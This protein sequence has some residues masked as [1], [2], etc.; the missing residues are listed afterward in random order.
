MWAEMLSWQITAEPIVYP[1]PIQIFNSTSLPCDTYSVP[2]FTGTGGNA[3]EPREPVL[4][5]STE[6]AKTVPTSHTN[7]NCIRKCRGGKVLGTHFMIKKQPWV[8]VHPYLDP[9]RRW[10][11]SK[12]QL[13]CLFPLSLGI[14]TK[15]V[16]VTLSKMYNLPSSFGTRRAHPVYLEHLIWFC[17]I[18]T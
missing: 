7:L 11:I 18:H 12:R 15:H 1:Q 8:I 2:K 14:G 5:L 4:F 13:V 9:S 16:K 3:E 10:W 6:E 17:K